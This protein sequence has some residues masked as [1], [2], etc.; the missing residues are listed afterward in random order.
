MGGPSPILAEG[1]GCISPPFL[2]GVSGLWLWKVPRHSWL[3]VLAV[4]ICHSW[5]DLAAGRG[6]WSLANPGS[7]S[8]VQ[9][10]AIPGRGLLLVFL[11]GPSPIL[12]EGPRC[13]SP[14]F[15][16]GVRCW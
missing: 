12:V 14:P 6:G 15:L 10:P 5:L 4:F 9:L 11:G 8:S 16:A 13:I 1:P 2:A 3:R 7:R